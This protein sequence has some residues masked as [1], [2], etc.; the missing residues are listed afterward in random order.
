MDINISHPS[1][2]SDADTFFVVCVFFSSLADK[3]NM[4]CSMELNRMCSKIVYIFLSLWQHT[5]FSRYF[6]LFISISVAMCLVLLTRNL[7]TTKNSRQEKKTE[8]K[9][10]HI[11]LFS[12]FSP[13][14][15]CADGK[16]CI[17][18]ISY[19]LCAWFANV[20]MQHDN[21]RDA[22]TIEKK[23]PKITRQQQQ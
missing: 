11:S 17:Q 18:C 15:S 2:L 12:C 8:I 5:F 1:L 3:G 14:F 4:T 20:S 21:D 10:P 16:Q 6:P 23:R 22:T 13:S 9:M 19:W 7:A